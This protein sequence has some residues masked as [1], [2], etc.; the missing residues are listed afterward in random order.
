MYRKPLIFLLVPLL[1]LAAEGLKLRK[2]SKYLTVGYVLQ[3]SPQYRYKDIKISFKEL[4]KIYTSQYGINAKVI[5]YDH[6]EDAVRDFCEGKLDNITGTG[7]VIAKNYRKLFPN[8]SL[9]YIAKKSD[10]YYTSHLLL[11]RKGAPESIRGCRVSIALSYYNNHLYLQRYAL[12]HEKAPYEDIVTVDETKNSRI[13]IFH[14]FFGQSDYAVVPEESWEVAKELNPQLG[15]KIEIADRS[16]NIMIYGAGCYSNRLSQD[17]IDTI[18]RIN[19]EVIHSSVGK[20]M[21]KL[22]QIKDHKLVSEKIF[23]PYIKYIQETE[24]LLA[25]Y[26]ERSRK[27][28]RR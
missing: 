26:K 20:K 11:R 12:E 8:A 23:Y 21:F 3:Y 10:S 22:L 18:R 7:V 19:E 9:Y 6:Q 16:P 24:R 2:E 13:A 28:N 5:Y 17:F 4:I 25:R 1:L 14:L 27:G 15:S